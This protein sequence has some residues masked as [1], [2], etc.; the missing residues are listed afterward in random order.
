MA[1]SF[2][3]N[4]P[5]GAPP[6]GQSSNFEN[7]NTRGP[8][9][10]VVCSVFIAIM[11]PFLL[12]RLYSKVWVIQS[13]GWD[14]GKLSLR[15]PYRCLLTY[16][17]SVRHACSGKSLRIEIRKGRPSNID[18]GRCNSVRRMYYLVYV[19]LIATILGQD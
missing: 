9:V 2:I 17:N 5:L 3:E 8:A 18:E 6:A 13:F 1:S 19:T 7:P 14:D 12:L 11:W 15:V 4:I 16:D 10:V